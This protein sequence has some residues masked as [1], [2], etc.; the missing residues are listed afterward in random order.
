[1]Q[2]YLPIW[3][4]AQANLPLWYGIWPTIGGLAYALARKEEQETAALI[5]AGIAANYLPWAVLDMIFRKIGFNYYMIYTLPFIALGLAFTCKLLPARGKV[6]LG[7][8]VFACLIFFLWF[9]PVRPM[10][11]IPT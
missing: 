8:Y 6:V 11:F 10:D 9:F 7:L 4:H 2:S 5:A 3:Y 1:V